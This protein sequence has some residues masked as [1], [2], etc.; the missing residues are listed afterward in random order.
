MNPYEAAARQK[1]AIALLKVILDAGGDSVSASRLGAHEWRCVAA[2]A[3]VHEP[4]DQ[5]KQEVIRLLI[6][7]EHAEV[8]A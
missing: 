6:K 4:S 1:K 2:V 5:T 7:W 3:K 8:A